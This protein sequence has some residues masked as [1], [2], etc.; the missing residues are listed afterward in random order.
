MLKPRPEF[1]ES[2]FI[3]DTLAVNQIIAIPVQAGIKRLAQLTLINQRLYEWIR[4]HNAM[5][6]NRRLYPNIGVNN[7][8]PGNINVN[9][10]DTGKLQPFTPSINLT[11]IAK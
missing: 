1:T 9:A 8:W 10:R 6:I 11:L 3:A 4:Q 5:A 7:H 2:R